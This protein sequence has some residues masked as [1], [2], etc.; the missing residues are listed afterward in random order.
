[1]QEANAADRITEVSL[2]DP[3]LSG[4]FSFLMPGLG[5]FYSQE[6]L[7]GSIFFLSENV[8]LFATILTFADLNISL[9]DD[10][11]LSVSLKVKR[12]ITHWE[13]GASVGLGIA[14]LA[15]HIFNIYDAV[16]S[17]SQYNERQFQNLGLGNEIAGLGLYLEKDIKGLCYSF[18]Y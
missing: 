9:V 6:P 7:K 8:L 11:G 16:D 1:M 13:I 4:V 10:F 2:K 5:Q 14:F 17:T 12:D 15:L 3:I 18:R